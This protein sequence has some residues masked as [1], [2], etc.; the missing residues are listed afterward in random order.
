MKHLTAVCASIALLTLSACDNTSQNIGSSLVQED[1]EVVICN[2]FSV[3]GHSQL[4]R[5]IESRTITQ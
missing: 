4:N 1:S 2:D 5:R 3:T